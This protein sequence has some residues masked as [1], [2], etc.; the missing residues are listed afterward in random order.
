L[1]ENRLDD[2]RRYLLMLG[3]LPD[4]SMHPEVRKMGGRLNP[5]N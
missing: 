3:D 1:A 2:A 5:P 4:Y